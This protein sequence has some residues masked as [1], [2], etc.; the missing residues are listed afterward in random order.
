MSRADGAIRW[1]A[2]GVVAGVAGTAGWVSYTHALD[3]VRLAGE[4][5]AVAYVLLAVAVGISLV[6]ILYF[7][8]V[9]FEHQAKVPKSSPTS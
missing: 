4:S 1:S 7:E 9:P 6:A 5:G 8:Q 3:V 2:S